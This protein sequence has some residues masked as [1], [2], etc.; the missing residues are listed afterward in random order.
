MIPFTAPLQVPLALPKEKASISPRSG[1]YSDA[2][3]D[4]DEGEKED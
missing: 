2:D 1:S 4:E 3:E